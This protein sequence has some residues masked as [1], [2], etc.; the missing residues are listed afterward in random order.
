MST[1]QSS[2]TRDR[3]SLVYRDHETK[4]ERELPLKILVVGDFA[5][6]E[7]ERPLDERKPIKVDG[8]SLGA[9]MAEHGLRLRFNCPSKLSEDPEDTLSVDLRFAS[10]SDFGP[11]WV[12][13]Q[14]PELRELVETRGALTEL[15]QWLGVSPSLVHRL[16]EALATP[17]NR[18][19]LRRELG[20]TR[21]PE[22]S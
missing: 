14:V 22:G 10:Y 2:P 9:V 15:K 20:I 13:Q 12:A 21:K 8:R 5:G 3:V 16:R 18:K 4:Q 1:K 19:Q 11:E 7:D 17:E 6:R